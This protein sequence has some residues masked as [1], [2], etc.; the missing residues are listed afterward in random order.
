MSDPSFRPLSNRQNSLNKIFSE[1]LWTDRTI[2][3]FLSY[4]KPP[5]AGSRIGGEVRWLLSLGSGLDG[6]EGVCHGGILMLIF[7]DIIH[8]LAS[9]DVNAKNSSIKLTAEFARPK[10]LRLTTL[11]D[12]R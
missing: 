8:E 9:Q 5:P 7:D 10:F 3:A 2:R 11:S 4:Y 12:I 1:T 6:L